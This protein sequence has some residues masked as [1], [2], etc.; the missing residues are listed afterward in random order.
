MVA[1]LVDVPLLLAYDDILRYPFSEYPAALVC[2]GPGDP[3]A[4]LEARWGGV[5]LADLLRGVQIDRAAHFARF[6]SA[7]GYQTG[8]PLADLGDA[9]LAYRMDGAPLRAEH[10]FPVRLIVPGRYGYKMPKWLQRIALTDTLVDGTW[11]RRGWSTAG[12]LGP[13]VAITTPIQRARLGL[14]AP[15]RLEGVATGGVHPL[16]AVELSIDDG[17]WM[18]VTYQQPEDAALARWQIDWRAPAPGVYMIR[19][20]AR[21]AAGR[22]CAQPHTITLYIDADPARPAL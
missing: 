21:D 22:D 11:E 19:A 15:I 14:D 12:L 18:P 1:G 3:P 6:E 8:L 20:R 7:D 5:R 13:Q 16:R 2:S 17:P 9:L 10:G 4:L